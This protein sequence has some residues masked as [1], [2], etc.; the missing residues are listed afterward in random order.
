M[1]LFYKEGDATNGPK[2]GS[3]II[4]AHVTNDKG[5]W[6][7]GFVKH[8]SHRWP[9]PEARYR[10]SKPELGTVDFVRV[11]DDITVA[12]MCAQRGYKAPD[13]PVPLDYDALDACLCWLSTA[14]SG[15]CAEIHMP[16]IGAGL[17]GGDWK[18]IE[19]LIYD[20]LVRIDHHSVT[21][22]DLPKSSK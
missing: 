22:F 3:P 9:E 5:G 2:K 4:I 14:A 18:I 6:G 16:R 10:E 1:P 20:R 17:A 7:M 12:N 13:N 8:L 19:D 15:L 11:A 21:V